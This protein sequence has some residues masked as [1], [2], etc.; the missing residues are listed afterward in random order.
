MLNISISD[1]VK[2]FFV[3]NFINLLDLREENNNSGWITPFRLKFCRKANCF[4]ICTDKTISMK[5]IIFRFPLRRM[6][7]KSHI[8]FYQSLLNKI[9]QDDNFCTIMTG[10]KDSLWK[11]ELLFLLPKNAKPHLTW[12]YVLN[13]EIL[14][15]NNCLSISENSLW[16]HVCFHLSVSQPLY[17]SVNCTITAAKINRLVYKNIRFLNI[18]DISHNSFSLHLYKFLSYMR[19]HTHVLRGW[20]VS[21]YIYFHIRVI[22]NSC[23][24]CFLF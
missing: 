1:Q 20:L 7:T 2:W 4:N 14:C 22:W 10:K 18:L 6:E 17:L 5:I 3:K 19:F 23:Q 11:M 13:G 21:K 8:C 16:R 9:L 24:N 15:N 12:Y